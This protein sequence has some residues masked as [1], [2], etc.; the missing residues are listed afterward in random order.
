MTV[1]NEFFE[2]FCALG[3]AFGFLQK[4]NVWVLREDAI[5]QDSSFAGAVKPPDV[6]G[7]DFH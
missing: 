6:P 3:R 1:G 4:D 7:C 5:F 2:R